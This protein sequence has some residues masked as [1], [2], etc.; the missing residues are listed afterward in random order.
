MEMHV[1]D[2]NKTATI[3]RPNPE[4]TN[5][6]LQ[7]RIQWVCGEYSAQKDKAAV[8]L[9]GQPR[10]AKTFPRVDFA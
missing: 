4:R 3:W 10:P 5:G 1:D 9:P 2:K 7:E 6:D 8:F